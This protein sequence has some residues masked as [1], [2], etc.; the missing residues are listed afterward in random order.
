MKDCGRKYL[1]FVFTFLLSAMF[2]AGC[3]LW[4]GK[5]VIL[6]TGFEEDELFFIE[7]L[8]C[9][10]AEFNVYYQ[11]FRKQYEAAYGSGIWEKQVEGESLKDRIREDTLSGI[12]RLKACNLLA[13]ERDVSL[14]EN[15]LK[16]CERAAEQ[17]MSSFTD[18]DRELLG[19]T[20]EDVVRMYQEYALANKVYRSITSGINPEISDDEARTIKVKQILIRTTSSDPLGNRVPDTE[21]QKQEDLVLAHRIREELENGEDFDILADRYHEG[22]SVEYSVGK[23]GA[24]PQEFID[25]AFSLDKDQISDV[26]ETEYGYH[27]IKCISTLDRDETDANKKKILEKKRD[28]AFTEVYD[29]FVKKLYSGFHD[30]LWDSLEWEE[31]EPNEGESFL[32]IYKRLFPEDLS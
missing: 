6:T 21:E 5:Q 25:T 4:N 1:L 19:I 24:Y 11:T 22:T 23:D 31:K 29:E 16:Q 10:E 27:I 3:T 15:E 12:A 32:D 2:L 17:Y 9:R 30:E 7:D 14:T 20:E 28:Q 13:K 18:S 8:K 26:I